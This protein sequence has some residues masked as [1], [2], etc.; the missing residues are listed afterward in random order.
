MA[1]TES[2]SRDLSE[3]AEYA[4]DKTL[5]KGIA[6][7]ENSY[8]CVTIRLRNE[9]VSL[10]GRGSRFGGMVQWFLAKLMFPAIIGIIG[11]P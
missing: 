8:L 6:I 3:V 7:Y 5:L 9:P 11:D 1:R 2:Y 4:T 10:G